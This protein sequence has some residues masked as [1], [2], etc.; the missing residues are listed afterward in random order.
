MKILT[1]M[2]LIRAYIVWEAMATFP[3]KAAADI[4]KPE[5]VPIPAGTF[6]MGCNDCGLEDAKPE[7]RV[8]LDGFLMDKTPVTNT[9]YA[10]FVETTGYK[11]IA[12]RPLNQEN[13]PGVPKEGL[14]PGSAVF[15]PP[16]GLLPPIN[17]VQWWTYVPGANWRHPEG[18]SSDLKGRMDHPVTQVAF[19]DAKAYCNWRQ[20]RLPTEAEYEYAARG[21]LERNR[22]AWGNKL[23]P[24][25]QWVAN[26]WQGR[27]PV[28]N[29]KE[30][31][32]G[33]TSPVDAFPPNS[34]GLLDMG[35]NVWHWVTDWYQADY[36]QTL[37]KSGNIARN[38]RGPTS[39]YDPAEPGVRKKVQKG[40]S[41]LCAANYCVR[42]LVASRGKGEVD[43]ASSNL[44]FRC[45]KD[46]RK[47]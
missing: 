13:F 26:I 1:R 41:F 44:G 32:F 17:Y 20:A 10:A 16:Q 7:H 40:G 24:D 38:P 21:G 8:K 35:G 31:G 2:K 18:P 37:K 29:R 36:Y 22:Y 6:W 33:G 39:S 12:E 5:M 25:G 28:N 46:L 23:K 3:L 11:T 14:V 15:T 43:S 19:E 47:D 4:A 9:M 30:D 27:F 42:Y 45:V 34:Y